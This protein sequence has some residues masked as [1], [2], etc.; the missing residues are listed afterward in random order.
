MKKDDL[1]YLAHIE[2]ALEKIESY[3]RAGREAFGQDTMFQDAVMRRLEIVGEASK[4]V[5]SAAREQ[6]AGIP[7]KRTCGLRDV[8]IHGYAGIDLE[9]VWNVAIHDLPPLGERIKRLRKALSIKGS[10]D[11]TG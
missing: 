2:E 11:S 5:S 1:V 4:K 10:P 8:L 7:W 3:C 9:I 6:D